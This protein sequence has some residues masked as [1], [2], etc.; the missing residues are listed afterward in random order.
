MQYN[1]YYNRFFIDQACSVAGCCP[2]SETKPISSHFDHTLVNN[3]YVLYRFRCRH[4]FQSFNILDWYLTVHVSHYVYTLLPVLINTL[5]ELKHSC[6][7]H[8]DHIECGLGEIFIFCKT[9][10]PLNILAALSGSL[11]R[12]CFSCLLRGSIRINKRPCKDE[13]HKE[14][15]SNV[16]VNSMKVPE[17]CHQSKYIWRGSTRSWLWTLHTTYRS[18]KHLGFLQ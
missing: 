13:D 9:T 3:S 18:L 5:V 4:S 2:H 14:R 17:K 15:W 8:I 1:Y 11:L 10:V 12:E 7:D 16:L 6:S